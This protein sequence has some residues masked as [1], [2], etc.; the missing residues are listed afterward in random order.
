GP[1]RDAHGVAVGVGGDGV[2]WAVASA[3]LAGGVDQHELTLTRRRSCRDPV[4]LSCVERAWRR[5]PVADQEGEQAV[6][7]ERARAIGMFRYQLIREAAD[8]AHSTK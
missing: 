4:R 3:G 5:L 6:R 2:R 8:P 1:V 7:A